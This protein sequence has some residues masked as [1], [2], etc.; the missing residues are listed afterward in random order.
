M[1]PQKNLGGEHIVAASSVRLSVR[2]QFFFRAISQQLKAG[3]Q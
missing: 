2:E 1:L 3:I